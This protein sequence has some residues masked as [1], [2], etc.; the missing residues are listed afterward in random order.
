MTDCEVMDFSNLGRLCAS[1]RAGMMMLTVDGASDIPLMT[2]L[3]KRAA[4]IHPAAHNT[5]NIYIID[6]PM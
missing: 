2:G 5:K 4:R 6:G 1:L 3:R